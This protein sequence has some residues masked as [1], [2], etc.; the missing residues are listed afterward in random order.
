M[1]S[2]VN[3]SCGTDGKT[4]N[5]LRGGTKQSKRGNFPTFPHLISTEIVPKRGE[6]ETRASCVL[7]LCR[8]NKS[9]QTAT[10]YQHNRAPVILLSVWIDRASFSWSNIIREIDIMSTNA[11][12]TIF[13]AVTA[14]V[15]LSSLG[16]GVAAAVGPS[17]TTSAASPFAHRDLQSNNVLTVCP[18][19]TQCTRGRRCYKTGRE[20][21]ESGLD[22]YACGDCE[23]IDDNNDRCEFAEEV[24]CVVSDDADTSNWFCVNE[25]RCINDRVGSIE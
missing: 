24:F 13:L 22:E 15:A 23:D 4:A 7:Y 3:A 9:A 1:A 6:T 2:K 5:I 14:A 16:E 25:G 8:C 11:K 19:A 20:A 10:E 21:E 18:D 17:T 12:R